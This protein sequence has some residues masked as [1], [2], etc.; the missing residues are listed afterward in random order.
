MFYCRAVTL[1]FSGAEGFKAVMELAS[2]MPDNDPNSFAE[3]DK[4]KNDER[5]LQKHGIATRKQ[6]ADA[7]SKL[8]TNN[9]SDGTRR[10]Q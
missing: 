9:A 3:D 1:N 7:I 4:A 10:F 6:S 5:K 2:Y 8:L